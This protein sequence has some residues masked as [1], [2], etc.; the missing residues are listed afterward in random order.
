MSSGIPSS[1]EEQ[2]A[3]RLYEQYV[4]PLEQ[5]HWGE[6]AVVSPEG[7]VVLAPSLLDAVQKGT[8]MFGP[9]NFVFKVGPKAVGK[10]R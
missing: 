1:S 10:W 7:K 6:F 5:E 2:E 3:D 4:K 8:S 9:G